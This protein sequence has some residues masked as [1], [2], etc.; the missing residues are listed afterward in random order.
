M[1][2]I[3]LGITL[4]GGCCSVAI[5][6]QVITLVHLTRM[7]DTH[8]HRRPTSRTPRK[9]AKSQR[10]TKFCDGGHPAGIRCVAGRSECRFSCRCSSS[11]LPARP[12]ASS[13]R[14]TLSTASSNRARRVYGLDLAWTACIHLQCRVRPMCRGSLCRVFLPRSRLMHRPPRALCVRGEQ[15]S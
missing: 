12:S 11:M 4:F 13:N 7:M 1:G 6:A 9:A 8:V 15:G 5:L 14:A 10:R 2:W 3:V